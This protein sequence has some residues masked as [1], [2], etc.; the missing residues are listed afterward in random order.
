MATHRSPTDR[1]LPHERQH[2]LLRF[3]AVS[4][5]NVVFGQS[6][7][8]GLQAAF[9]WQ[10]FICNMV[11]VLVGTVPAYLMA[12]YWVW[13]QASR[14]GRIRDITLFWVVTAIGFVLSTAVIVYADT[15][16]HLTPLAVNTLNLGA[17]GG[18]WLA[19]FFVLE[20]VFS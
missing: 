18:V 20:R 3:G 9:D 1:H 10:P 15:R 16:W 17:F 2:R 4:G 19:K 12:R 5:F 14:R 11:A 13:R 8:F 7:L 6:L